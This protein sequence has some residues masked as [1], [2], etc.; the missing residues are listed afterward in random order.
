MIYKVN[1]MYKVSAI[2]IIYFLSVTLNVYA[3]G[4]LNPAYATLK[5]R[6]DATCHKPASERLFFKYKE[7]YTEGTLKYNIFDA[8]RNNVTPSIALFKN[9]RTNW[10]DLDVSTLGNGIYILEVE[11]E[12]REL[13]LLRF[14]VE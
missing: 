10:F 9:L 14:K 6:L 2:I 4:A 5:N 7:R 1:F 8:D 11:N 3:Q 13:Y 12:K